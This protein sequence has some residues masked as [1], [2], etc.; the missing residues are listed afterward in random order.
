MQVKL[1]SVPLF[2]MVMLVYTQHTASVEIT[3][4][5]HCD[6]LGVTEARRVFQ[7]KNYAALAP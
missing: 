6:Q 1:E 3:T 4:S 2:K 7:E 5:E